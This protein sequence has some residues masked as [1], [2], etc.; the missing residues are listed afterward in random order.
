MV[1]F[2]SPRMG[3]NA[4]VPYGANLDILVNGVSW[5]RGRTD[6][7]GIAPKTH[8]ALTLSADPVLRFRLIMLPTVLAVTLIC[9]LGIFTYLARRA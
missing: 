5:L 1:V 9:A 6:L 4:I 2:S 7:Q 3:D 8:V